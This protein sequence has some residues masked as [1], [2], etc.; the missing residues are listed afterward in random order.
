VSEKALKQRQRK[1]KRYGWVP[2]LPDARDLE[3]AAPRPVIRKLPPKVNLLDQS[4]AMPPVYDQGRLGSCTAN[5]INAMLVY[6]EHKLG[7]HVELP[8]RSRLF[9]YYCERV[10]ENT[11]AED[12]GAM[13]RDG[14]KVI[15]NFGA[16]A[17]SSWPY[18]IGQFAV[19]PPAKV[20]R[21][22]L[23][24][25]AASYRRVTRDLRQMKGCLADGFP[26]VFGFS[27]YDS[28]ESDAVARTG[29]VPLPK[30]TE[31]LLGGHAVLAVGYDDG[32]ERF[33]VRNSWGKGWGDDGYFTLPYQFLSSRALSADFWT[34]R[35]AT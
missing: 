5:A 4:R 23:Q 14:M 2:D 18:N 30:P 26:F 6:V 17:E 1:V 11:V 20:F 24:H 3:Y 34:L 9:V 7:P 32:A 31:S 33:L 21:A 15:A 10:L 13:I 35:T 22:A 12:A 8:A 28:F 16:P 25:R 27:V 19:R 29:V